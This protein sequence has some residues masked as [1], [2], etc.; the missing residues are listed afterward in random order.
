MDTGFL[1]GGGFAL[2]IALLGWSDQIRGT[3]ERTRIQEREFLDTYNF[4]WEHFRSL[5]RTSESPNAET[6]LAAVLRILGSGG[7]TNQVDVL[8][9]ED[10]EHLDDIRYKLENS[11][12]IRYWCVFIASV[13]MLITG[14]LSIYLRGSILKC[15]FLT[16]THVYSAIWIIL[17]G[18]I[19]YFTYR[20]SVQE[21]DLRQT[22]AK[23]DDKLRTAKENKD[24]RSN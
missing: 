1:L 13:E 4:R 18:I 24:P 14:I 11:Y 17:V 22:L 5:I 8:L 12:S 16:W 23:I 3:Q 20:I 6:R 21:S 19:V 15:S 7:L 9:L 2:L 10:F